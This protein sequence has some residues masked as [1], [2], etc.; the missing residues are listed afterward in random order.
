MTL[1]LLDGI[2]RFFLNFGLILQN[3]SILSQAAAQ[4]AVEETLRLS[5]CWIG[6]AVMPVDDL[7]II[8][9]KQREI[10]VPAMQVEH[11]AP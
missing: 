5:Q 4:R 3:E 10:D 11:V 9:T 8:K 2:C 7:K 6:L 1:R